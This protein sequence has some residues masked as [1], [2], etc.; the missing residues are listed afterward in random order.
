MRILAF[1]KCLED[2]LKNW[3]N[4]TR[5][6]NY[7]YKNIKQKIKSDLLGKYESRIVED[8]LEKNAERIF[9]KIQ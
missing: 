4:I 2:Q 5:R 1:Y 3:K 9:Q 7:D 8:I 6:Y